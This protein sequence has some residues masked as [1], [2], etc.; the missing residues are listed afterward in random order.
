MHH[1]HP[2]LEDAPCRSSSWISARRSRSGAVP[3]RPH[4]VGLPLRHA[5]RQCLRLVLSGPS[6]WPRSRGAPFCTGD[7]AHGNGLLRRLDDVLDLELRD[8]QAAREQRADRGAGEPA[9]RPARRCQGDRARPAPLGS[10][11]AK[12]RTWSRSRVSRARAPS[13]DVSFRRGPVWRS[14]PS[15]ASGSPSWRCQIAGVK[16]PGCPDLVD[17]GLVA[18]WCADLGRAGK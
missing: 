10:R 3:R 12:T 8:G 4:R 18:Q 1:D 9:R 16:W 13:D 5:H 11:V 2:F 17:L 7:G 14:L 15:V 6:H